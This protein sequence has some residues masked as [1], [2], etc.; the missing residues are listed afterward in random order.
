[1]FKIAT[2]FRQNKKEDKRTILYFYKDVEQLLSYQFMIFLLRYVQIHLYML[3]M[4][5]QPFTQYKLHIYN[6]L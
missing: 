5:L 6:R 3:A 2:N 4:N 1:M